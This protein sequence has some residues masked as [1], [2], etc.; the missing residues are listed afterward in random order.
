MRK[1]FYKVFSALKNTD[2]VVEVCIN[3]LLLLVFMSLLTRLKKPRYAPDNELRRVALL[4]SLI[5]KIYNA[6]PYVEI[7][8]SLI[9]ISLKKMRLLRSARNR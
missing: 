7:K 4:F 2:Y 9:S 8:G 3:K 6:E 1:D 5:N